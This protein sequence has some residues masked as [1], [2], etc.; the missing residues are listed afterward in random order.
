MKPLYSF[1]GG[2]S[3]LIKSYT[4]ESLLPTQPLKEYAEPFFGG[5]AMFC[6]LA[7]NGVITRR[8]KVY[9][10]DLYF[11]I[12]SLLAD[13][14]DN[15]E[16]FSQC[17]QKL[18]QEF[19]PLNGIGRANKYAE[20][21]KKYNNNEFNQGGQD[22][23]VWLFLFHNAFNGVLQTTKAQPRL[24]SMPGT[25]LLKATQGA[26][27]LYWTRLEQWHSVLTNYDI[28]LFNGDFKVV[29]LATNGFTFVDPPYL[30]TE[31]YY[32]GK[33]I[34]YNAP[35]QE[36]VLAHFSNAGKVLISNKKADYF[37][38]V[39]PMYGYGVTEFDYSYRLSRKTNSTIEIALIK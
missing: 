35:F 37:T 39:G 28:E 4:K 19:L 34:G 30:D 21:R 23:A 16:E 25:K 3:K 13:I 17:L 24:S 33:K 11:P 27:W 5:G 1:P 14:R 9:I 2:K 29:P 10:G 6:H 7:A 22:S 8:T 31:I 38:N 36:D 26:Q 32:A 20:Y 15:W 12:I 18:E